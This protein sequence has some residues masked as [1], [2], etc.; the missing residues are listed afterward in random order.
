MDKE[1]VISNIIDS[2]AIADGLAEKGYI[3]IPDFLDQQLMEEILNVFNVHKENGRFKAAGIGA[4][5]EYHLDKQ[6]R[7]DYIKWIEPATALPPTKA[8]LEKIEQVRAI[9]NRMLYL[10]I[11]DYE[12]HFAIYPPGA[13]Y[14]RHLDQFKSNG[15]R[16]I[17]FVSYLNFDW[18]PEDG[19]QLRIYLPGGEEGETFFD[20]APEAG[21]LVLFRSDVIEHEVLLSNTHRYSITGWMLDLPKELT[22]L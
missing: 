19:G 11:K 13:F 22:F 7:G 20:I 16:K 21:K 10:G 15:H 17:S 9:L 2:E 5:S 12:A 1:I 18:M 3:V 14:K 8:F 6:I 4:Q